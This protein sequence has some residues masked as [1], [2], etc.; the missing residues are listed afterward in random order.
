MRTLYVRIV[1]TFIVVALISSI[2]ALLFTNF[3]YLAKL[4]GYNEQKIASIGKEIRS[5]YG[6]SKAVSLDSYL[7]HI[8]NMGFQLYAVNDRLEG[9]FYGAPFKHPQFDEAKIR[10]VLNGETYRGLLEE[11]RAP[12]VT[13]YFENSI[14]NSVGLPLQTGDGHTVALFVRPNLEEQIGEV[15]IFVALLLGLTFAFSIV[16]IVVLTRFIVHP[17]RKL[18]EATTRIVGGD[19]DFKLDRSRRDEI[20]ELARHFTQMAVSLQQLDEMRQEFVANVSHEIQSPLTSIQGFV[21]TILDKEASP[22]EERRYLQIIE[23]ESRRL[24]SMS[25]QLLTLA[26]LDKE[27]AIIKRSSYRVDEQLRQVLIVTEPQWSDK[28]LSVE[29]VLPETVISADP[30]LMYQVWLNLIANAIK[31]TPHGGRL[32]VRTEADAAGVTV[33]IEDTGIGIPPEELP[34][35]FERFY[36]AD[37]ARK[38]TSS[39]SGLGLAI[40]HTIVKLHGG[41]VRASSEA[42]KGTTF[43]IRLPHL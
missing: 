22:E 40:V 12:M 25:K 1:L 28:S 4:R 26:A 36:K 13:S 3:Y 8:A 20:G 18:T 43:I 17:V 21:Q 32:I 6:E 30:Q 27:K 11:R 5:L 24:S 35:I 42:G 34:H 29:P 23:A 14:R 7:T 31:F 2:L 9:K 15:R 41:T 33:E 19:Y 16:L 38:R 37:K 39:G 10:R